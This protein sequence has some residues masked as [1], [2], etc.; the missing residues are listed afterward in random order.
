[1]DSKRL[2]ELEKRVE[3]LEALVLQKKAESKKS[4]TT[5]SY[6]GPKG[7]IL[8]I[9]EQGFLGKPRT[10]DEIAAELEKNG[11]YYKRTVIQTALRRMATPS[12][13]LSS[14]ENKESN[15]LYVVRK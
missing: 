9:S 7:G 6:P 12:G 3:K 8:L 11:Y 14:M 13:P 5:T 1:M 10:A 2:D 4:T 15:K